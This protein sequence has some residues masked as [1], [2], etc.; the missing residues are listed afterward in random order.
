MATNTLHNALCVT[1]NLLKKLAFAYRNCPL[2]LETTKHFYVTLKQT[3]V[4]CAPAVGE[5]ALSDTAIRPS[6]PALGAQLP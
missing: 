4:L 2:S 3:C 1:V 5:G 6:V